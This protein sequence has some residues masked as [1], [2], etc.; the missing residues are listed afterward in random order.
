MKLRHVYREFQHQF[1][2][3]IRIR[4]TPLYSASFY[5]A[6]SGEKEVKRS[7]PFSF[8]QW[9]FEKNIPYLRYVYYRQEK[10]PAVVR[11]EHKTNAYYL[12][13]Y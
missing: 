10:F 8:K 2:C 5:A 9:S 11:F 4:E 3:A 6:Y 13:D 7:Q 1:W 12:S